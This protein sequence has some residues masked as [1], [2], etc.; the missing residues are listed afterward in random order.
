MMKFHGDLRR[1]F[2]QHAR[3]MMA[4]NVT[5]LEAKTIIEE[6][7]SDM[8]KNKSSDPRLLETRTWSK[9]WSK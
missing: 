4:M 9:S 3:T 8:K 1:I 5:T 6:D 7:D 2:S